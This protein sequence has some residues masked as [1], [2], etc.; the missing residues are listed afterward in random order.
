MLVFYFVKAAL[1]FVFMWLV[2][3]LRRYQRNI[4]IAKFH[5][6]VCNVMLCIMADNMGKIRRNIFLK[7]MYLYTLL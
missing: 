1:F 4:L 6:E 2:Q 7:L 5:V 3:R